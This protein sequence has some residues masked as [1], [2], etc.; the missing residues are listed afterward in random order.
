MKVIVCN[1]RILFNA[2]K[3]PCRVILTYHTILSA[4]FKDLIVSADSFDCDY[5]RIRDREVFLNADTYS[6]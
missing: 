1:E 3:K 4:V 5:T 6:L 2:D